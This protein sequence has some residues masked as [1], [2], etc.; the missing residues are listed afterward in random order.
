[1]NKMLNM[2]G[3]AQCAGKTISGE[4][5]CIDAIRNKSAHV[6]FLASDA[7]INTTKRIVD[8]ATFYQVKVIN[9]FSSSE[10]SKAIGKN[11]RMVVAICDSG[12][13]KKIKEMGDL[14]GKS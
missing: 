1:M 8:K 12:F 10:L 4:S 3:L 13:A 9:C 14:N 11:N 2:L 7:G 6:V 5:F